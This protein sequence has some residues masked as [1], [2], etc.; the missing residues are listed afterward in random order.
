MFILF[1]TRSFCL[2]FRF[3]PI[4]L[5][6]VTF[7]VL[8]VCSLL[9]CDRAEEGRTL[10][11]I[12]MESIHEN[13]LIKV[14]LISERKG[15]GVVV[16]R[17]VPSGA[18]LYYALPDMAVLYS[19]FGSQHCSFC[20][21]A[22]DKGNTTSSSSSLYICPTCDQ[23]SLCRK[24]VQI[25]INQVR[26]GDQNGN[27]QENDD[28]IIE[29]HP[30]VVTHH[31]SCVWYN[32]LPSSVRAPG[33]DTDY[34][35]FCLLYG[36]KVLHQD[37]KCVANLNSLCDNKSSQA[38]DVIEFCTAF[39]RDKIVRT[40]GPALTKTATPASPRYPVAPETLASLLL[41][42]RCNSLGFPFTAE[43]TIGWSLHHLVCMINHSCTPNAAIVH[44]ECDE[45]FLNI[46][47]RENNQSSLAALVGCFGVKTL[48][49][50]KK[51]EEVTISYLDLGTYG[52][53]VESRTRVLLETFRF[54]CT[55]EKCVLQRS[56]RKAST[57]V[58]R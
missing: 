20:Y 23:F 54:L 45:S 14:E 24:C 40:F 6:L 43:E 10:N 30:V 49:P 26:E 18:P 46:A 32:E 48:R 51:G 39:A 36:A 50:I 29:R 27:H 35:R 15:R 34:L 58:T 41:K 8:C 38:Q 57:T 13:E 55:C 5:S 19:Q 33:M 31:S 12:V 44:A 9:F 2:T 28:A 42:V 22:L 25:L 16:Q 3:L 4:Y 53:D 47:R 52:D 7:F 17:D 21:I 56:Q 1:S 11:L 37:E